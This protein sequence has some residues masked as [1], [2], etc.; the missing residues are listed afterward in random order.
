[1]KKAPGL[2][3]P[4][5]VAAL[6]WLQQAAWRS[7]QPSTAVARLLPLQQVQASHVSVSKCMHGV[8]T[9]ARGKGLPNGGIQMR[10]K[11]NPYQ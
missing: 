3:Q 11:R 2:R 6:S 8:V 10:R 9:L 4:M 1:M 7:R 5:R